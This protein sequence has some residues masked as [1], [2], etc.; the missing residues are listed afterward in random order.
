MDTLNSCVA[1][2][3]RYKWKHYQKEGIRF[4]KDVK[5]K[6]CAESIVIYDKEKEIETNKD[7]LSYL[8]NP[9]KVVNYFQ[10]KSRLEM[11]LDTL[12]KIRK[13][14]NIDTTHISDVFG[15]Q[16]NP[17]LTQFNK[18][19]GGGE[20]ENKQCINNYETYAMNAIIE[21]HNGDIKKIEQEMK[22]LDVYSKNS[23]NGLSERMKKIKTLIQ[24]RNEELYN[25]RG[26]LTEIR[27]KLSE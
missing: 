10:G 19:F 7:F 4:S 3:R 24:Q 15:S 11:D 16:E 1:N 18:I 9:D 2:Y 23:R 26:I 22:D 20:I 8:D 17:L 14:L 27:K 13:A 12:K 25:S 5:S 6:E 21:K